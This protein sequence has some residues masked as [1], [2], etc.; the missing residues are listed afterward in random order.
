WPYPEPLSYSPLAVNGGIHTAT[1]PVVYHLIE[2]Q[3]KQILK[4]TKVDTTL[5]KQQ[6]NESVRGVRTSEA[7]GDKVLYPTGSTVNQDSVL[8]YHDD[9]DPEESSGCLRNDDKESVEYRD[10][11]TM[12]ESPSAQQNNVWTNQSQPISSHLTNIN[13]I[14][15]NAKAADKCNR[16]KLMIMIRP[17]K[18]HIEAVKKQLMQFGISFMDP[19]SLTTNHKA[20]MDTMYVPG[21]HNMLSMYQST[22][23]THYLESDAMA[24]KY[25]TDSQLAAI[26]AMS[27]VFSVNNEKGMKVKEQGR[28]MTLLAQLKLLA[29]KKECKANS[30][31]LL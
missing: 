13:Q 17:V 22:I 6:E 25:L 9:S 31:N 4:L 30:T 3:N 5:E 21:F 28:S 19:A 26:A 11:L 16:M 27:P 24:A 7:T 18:P 10:P 12:G 8:Q 2:D 14:L 1:D 15:Q 20:V 23:S 29:A